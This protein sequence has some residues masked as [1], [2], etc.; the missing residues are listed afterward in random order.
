[1]IRNTHRRCFS[2]RE[3]E[4]AIAQETDDWE[5][6]RTAVT[7]YRIAIYFLIHDVRSTASLPLQ[8]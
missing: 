5:S 7:D 2:K 3:E 8:R 4:K 1:M 6:W